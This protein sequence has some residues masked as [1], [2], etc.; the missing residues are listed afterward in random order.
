MLVLPAFVLLLVLAVCQPRR[1]R[2]LIR[3]SN[4]WAP[5]DAPHWHYAATKPLDPNRGSKKNLN[6]PQFPSISLNSPQFSSFAL[7]FPQFPSISLNALISGGFGEHLCLKCRPPAV[8][9]FLNLLN[10]LAKFCPFP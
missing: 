2:I 5:H 1:P 6:F 8:S 4:H 9:F 3:N 7:N 10:L